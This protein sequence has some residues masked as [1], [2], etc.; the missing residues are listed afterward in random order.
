[1]TPRFIAALLAASIALLVPPSSHAQD[2]A[3]TATAEP[4]QLGATGPDETTSTPDA[5]ETSPAPAPARVG[6]EHP[7]LANG[8][9]GVVTGDE[10][11][12]PQTSARIGFVG[13]TLHVMAAQYEGAIF[14]PEVNLHLVLEPGTIQR[15]GLKRYGFNRQIHADLGDRTV[16]FSLSGGAFVDAKGTTALYERLVASGVPSFKP[17]R[18]VGYPPKTPITIYY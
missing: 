10:K 15:I 8:S 6:P 4:A 3:P 17:K 1:M 5:A 2:S 9:F 11:V 13:D 14:N 18:F 12:T 16:V 7:D